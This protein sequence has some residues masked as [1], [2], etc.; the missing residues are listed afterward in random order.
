MQSRGLPNSSSYPTTSLSNPLYNSR[1]IDYTNQ[2]GKNVRPNGL[3]TMSL[4]VEPILN[5]PLMIR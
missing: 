3:R 5:K 1:S 2:R 4:E